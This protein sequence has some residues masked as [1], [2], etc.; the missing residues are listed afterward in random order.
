[1]TEDR[2]RDRLE[3]ISLKEIAEEEI[4]SIA[5]IA[6]HLEVT[7]KGNVWFQSHTINQHLPEMKLL[8]AKID[9]LIKALEEQFRKRT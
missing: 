9:G 3:R 6:H 2:D 5:Q 1:M 7:C 8:R 4:R